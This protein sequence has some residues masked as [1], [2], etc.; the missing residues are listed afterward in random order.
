MFQYLGTAFCRFTLH[1]ITCVSQSSL[2]AQGAILSFS[3]FDSAYLFDAEIC[4]KQQLM[5]QAIATVVQLLYNSG[6]GFA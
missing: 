6:L 5:Y 3:C 4:L 1:T 2:C